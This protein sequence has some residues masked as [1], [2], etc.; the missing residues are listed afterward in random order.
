MEMLKEE[1]PDRYKQVFA[2]FIDADQ[3]EDIEDMYKD[4]HSKIRENPKYTKKE[5]AGI[6]NKVTGNLVTTSKGT[7]YTRERKISKEQKKG[8][9]QQK[10]MA[11]ARKLLAA[12]G[13]AEEEEE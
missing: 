4:A 2:K 3:E 6:T 12:A 5:N 1:D 13:D 8:R 7:K 11:A 9:V 10:K